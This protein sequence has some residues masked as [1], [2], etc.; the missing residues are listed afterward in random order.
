MTQLYR[1]SVASRTRRRIVPLKATLSGRPYVASWSCHPQRGSKSISFYNSVC[2][3][4]TY[5]DASYL[6]TV[7]ER[8]TRILMLQLKQG[9]EPWA[10][11]RLPALTCRLS[12]VD[13]IS[14]THRVSPSS[15]CTRRW[16]R[17]LGKDL[18]PSFLFFWPKWTWTS[19]LSLTSDSFLTLRGSSTSTPS[20]HCRLDHKLSLST[21]D[22]S[23]QAP[24]QSHSIK[25]SALMAGR[26]NLSSLPWGIFISTS[27][28]LH[29]STSCIVFRLF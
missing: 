9:P 22:S 3:W 16:P 15:D 17:V 23:L 4:I 1:V 29:L 26:A 20:V 25:V 28:E 14:A 19:P 18:S 7:S 2:S 5:Q 24:S 13:T 27:V 10:T 12:R 11:T 8:V 21:M 6:L